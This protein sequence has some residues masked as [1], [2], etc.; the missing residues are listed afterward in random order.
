M[1]KI[2]IKYSICVGDPKNCLK[3]LYAN[4]KTWLYDDF[5]LASLKEIYEKD[6]AILTHDYGNYWKDGFNGLEV[7]IYVTDVDEFGRVDG[8]D[9]KAKA[10]YQYQ[11]HY[12]GYYMQ[13]VE[14]SMK[15]LF[16]NFNI[17]QDIIDLYQN[18]ILNKII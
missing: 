18:K 4:S 6:I 10:Y 17:V 11:W 2:A 16:D 8:N 1:L 5:S 12:E 3:N 15:Y 14:K 7:T 13:D 9:E